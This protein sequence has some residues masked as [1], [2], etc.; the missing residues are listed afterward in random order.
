MQC[1][2]IF[3]GMRLGGASRYRRKRGLRL[4]DR[5]SFRISGIYTSEQID[6][7]ERARSN[8]LAFISAKG[9]KFKERDRT[10][11]FAMNGFVSGRNFGK[12]EGSQSTM[13]ANFAFDP[14]NKGAPSGCCILQ[15]ALRLVRPETIKLCQLSSAT[16]RLIQSR[17]GFHPISTLRYR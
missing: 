6:A 10:S 5:R 7:N 12:G 2:M 11:V 4:M 14:M 15:T 3:C 8:S 17:S 13:R 16:T 9:S 1:S